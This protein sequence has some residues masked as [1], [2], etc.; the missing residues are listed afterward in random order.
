MEDL[1]ER[2]IMEM[3]KKH[4]EC[5]LSEKQHKVRRIVQKQLWYEIQRSVSSSMRLGSL[6]SVNFAFDLCKKN[7]YLLMFISPLF[8][9]CFN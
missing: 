8:L 9:K 6:F 7:L 1:K 3:Q 4:T 5:T 2:E